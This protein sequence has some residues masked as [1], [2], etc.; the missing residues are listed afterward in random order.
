[1][2][3]NQVIGRDNQNKY[4]DNHR[5]D[6]NNNQSWSRLTAQAGI[7]MWRNSETSHVPEVCADD[8]NQRT[9][10]SFMI[11]P[12]RRTKQHQNMQLILS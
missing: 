9:D 8:V 1:M 11:K 4:V 3:K 10:K 6:V 5:L 2:I 7:H 12:D